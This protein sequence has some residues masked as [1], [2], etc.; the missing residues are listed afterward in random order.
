MTHQRATLPLDTLGCAAAAVPAERA[1]RAVTGVTQVFVNPVTEMAYVE[2]DAARCDVHTLRTTL[3]N[4]GFDR[5]PGHLVSDSRQ[6]RP[7]TARF[8]W[9]QTVT[10]RALRSHRLPAVQILHDQE[11]TP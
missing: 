2:Y 3:E 7:R 11:K 9:L 8:A 5:A 10:H 4:L 6:R 1:L